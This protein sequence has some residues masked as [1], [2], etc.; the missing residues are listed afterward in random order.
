MTTL[1][2]LG[3][4]N[5]H[6]F[7]NSIVAANLMSVSEFGNPLREVYVLHSPESHRVLAA[8]ENWL[9][10]LALNK[11]DG[12]IITHRTIEIGFDA[13]TDA[14]AKFSRYVETAVRAS[15]PGQMIV[16][17]TNG[18]AAH[19]TLLSTVAYILDVPHLYTIDVSRL[20]RPSRE[21]GFLDGDALRD[22][23]IRSPDSTALDAIAH[24]SMTEV[25]RYR[26]IVDTHAQR[27]VG[28]NPSAADKEFFSANLL[29]SIRMKLQGDRSRRRDNAL[30]RIAS[31]SIAASVEDL[32][33]VL[34]TQVRSERC[35]DADRLTFGE[36]L[37]ILRD[38][39]E[40]TT[41]PDFDHEFFRRF[42]D[43]MLY[44]R[45][46]T[47]HK[48]KLLSDVERFKADLAVKM[49]FPFL[50]FYAEIVHPLLAASST[51]VAPAKIQT[52]SASAISP[53]DVFLVGLDGDDTGAILED[54]F[55]FANDEKRFRQLSTGVERALDDISKRVKDFN[56]KNSIIF[57]AGDDLLF[58]GHVDEPLLLDLQQIY[59]AKANGHT[60]SIGYGK[61]FREVY[62][63]LKLAKTKPGKNSIVGVELK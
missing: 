45:N 47:T 11:I 2:V 29:H 62:V 61:T 56:K 60:C 58:R 14:I 5:E 44:L 17:L 63:A 43:F 50:E 39:V 12:D 3:N 51:A 54:L 31:S 27:Y 13:P 7:A 6:T 33:R 28:V 26:R 23:Y 19:K 32:I 16:D 4:T 30:Y 36:R 20:G 53:T 18:M 1:L 9:Q 21:L 34:M 42:N 48:G 15:E 55:L 38:H 46:S 37:T 25:V 59:A 41:R 10:H 57:A 24:L 49:S 8:S 22:A 35:G 40:S 52:L